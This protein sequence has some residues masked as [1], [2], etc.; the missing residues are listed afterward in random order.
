MKIGVLSQWYPPETGPATLPEVLSRA[1]AVRGHEVSVVTGFPNYPTGRL[2]E[3]YRIRRRTDELGANGVKVR[4]VAL[5]PSHDRSAVRRFL[6][7]SSFALSATVSGRSAL[8]GMDAFWVYN[9][10]ATIGLPSAAVTAAGGP[11]HLMHVMDLWPDSILFSGLGGS[12]IYTRLGWAL[13]RWCDWTYRQAGAIA[14]ISRA[15]VD[16]LHA[17]GVGR[18]KIHHVPVWTDEALF[19]PRERDDALARELGVGDRFTLLYAGS[20]G[21]AQG[22]DSLLEVCSRVTDLQDFRCLIA[23]SGVAERRLRDRAAELRLSNTTF[24]GRWPAAEMGGLMSI[25]DIHLVS[26]SDDPLSAMTMPSKLP[27][28]LASGRAVVASSTGEASRVV[29]EAG[30]GW[31]VRPGDIDAFED[32][33]RRAHSAGRLGT[34][35]LGRAGRQYYE[36]RLSLESGVDA[37]EC[38]LQD[39]AARAGG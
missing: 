30:A 37:V 12:R 33:V 7:Y 8:R 36:Q 16:E 11:P 4:R 25:G 2:V 34:A 9:S 15:V 5:Y 28:I 39:I 13:Q 1:L 35:E 18:D 24:L 20:L 17:R 14:C 32:V 6:N 29:A 21:D 23:G 10:P 22:L 19:Y 3:G 27:A 31:S 26:L 38:L